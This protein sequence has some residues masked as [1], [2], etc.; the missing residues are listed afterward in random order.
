LLLDVREPDEH[1]L[2]TI[3]GARLIPLGEVQER[4]TELD[5]WREREV[6]VYCHHGMRSRRVAV[7]LEA[8]GFTQVANLEGGI[9]RWSVEVDPAVR[10][11]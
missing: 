7:W 4:V 11:Y 10:R 5:A 9:D 3:A 6:V 2:A 1:A 8:R